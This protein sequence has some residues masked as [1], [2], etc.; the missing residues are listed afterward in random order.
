[1]KPNRL[2]PHD[3]F[4]YKFPYPTASVQL[5]FKLEILLPVSEALITV[6]EEKKKAVLTLQGYNPGKRINEMATARR[7]SYSW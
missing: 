2:I 1:M 6:S 7:S 3:H 5:F 4:L